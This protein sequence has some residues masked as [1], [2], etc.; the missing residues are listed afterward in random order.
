M[1]DA[2]EQKMCVDGKALYELWS[3]VATLERRLECLDKSHVD[4]CNTKL[5]EAEDQ[6]KAL[7]REVMKLTT[8]TVRF[9]W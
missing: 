6:I 1:L 2:A 5:E 9:E 7:E 4:E 8:R 3:R